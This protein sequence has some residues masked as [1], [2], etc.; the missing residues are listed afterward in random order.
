MIG[1]DAVLKSEEIKAELFNIE[2]DL[3]KY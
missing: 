2:H 3:W 1:L